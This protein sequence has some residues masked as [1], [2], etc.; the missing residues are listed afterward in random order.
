MTHLASVAD[1]PSSTT[2]DALRALAPSAAGTDAARVPCEFVWTCTRGRTQLCCQLDV[3]GDGQHR[4]T[5]LR[6][7]RTYG[8]YEF[9]E[10]DAALTFAARLRSTFEGNG[11][12]N[13]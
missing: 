10:R 4:L 2:P 3:H 11:W 1:A 12:A 6:N 5:L 9:C 8:Q 7:S 13:A